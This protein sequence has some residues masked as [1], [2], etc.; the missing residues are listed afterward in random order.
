MRTA[1][2]AMVAVRDAMGTVRANPRNIAGAHVVAQAVTVA[3]TRSSRVRLRWFT[4]SLKLVALGVGGAITTLAIAAVLGALTEQLWLA[5]SIAAVVA[6]VLPLVLADRLLPR[7][8][9]S[10]PGLV[11]DV[12]ASVWMI[13]AAVVIAI[14]PS[15][16]QARLGAQ[17]QALDDR[18]WHRPAWALRWIGE[19]PT[20]VPVAAEPEA[21]SVVAS[22]PVAAPA[23]TPAAGAEFTPAPDAGARSALEP[24]ALFERWAPSVVT[25]HVR[26]SEGEGMG[27]GFVIDARG[28]VATNH[29]VIDGASAIEVKLFD[30][31]RIEKVELL[32]A[33]PEDDL[34]LIRVSTDH[35]L[36]PV[37][38]GE[39]EKVVVGEAVVV[40][41]NP[42]GLEHT[43]TDGLVS[44]RRLYSGRKFIQMSAPVSPGNSGG[45][46]FNRYG[47]VVGVTVAKLWGENLNLAVPIDQLK[48]MIKS[49]YPRARALGE[50]RW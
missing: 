4:L 20:P 41:G 1:R 39:S 42:I 23:A 48:P 6:I 30:G 5:L 31:T 50:S 8:G 3:A 37:V 22:A 44:A 14:A 32:D 36:V 24:A 28:T 34:A 40:I 19:L 25:I 45:P 27:T 9:A 11:S 2:D 17:A 12:M 43:L 35:A 15:R 47:D 18:G 29:H 49:E 21:P 10:R 26:S 7:S 33:D 16:L 38:L 13:A 46:V